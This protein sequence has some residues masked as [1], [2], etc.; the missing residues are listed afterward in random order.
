MLSTIGFLIAV[1]AVSVG[2]FVL[3]TRAERLGEARARRSSAYDGGIG[4]GSDS[5]SL[6]SW[7]GY[8]STVDSSNATDSGACTTS[9][10]DSGSVGDC[11]SSGDSGGGSFSSD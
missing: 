7:V 11:G 6:A 10:W 5:W 4:S 3:T 2:I 8:Y 9:S 1:A